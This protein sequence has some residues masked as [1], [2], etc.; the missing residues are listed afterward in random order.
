MRNY[1]GAKIIKAESMDELTFLMKYK[2]KISVENKAG[3]PG[4]HLEDSD[5]HHSWSPKNTFENAY[6]L[7][8][9]T[10]M[11]LIIANSKQK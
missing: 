9:D 8:T 6:R 2:G 11:C 3:Q 1:I 7:I 5:S 4:Y 10:E